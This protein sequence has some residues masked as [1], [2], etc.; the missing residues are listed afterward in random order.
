MTRMEPNYAQRVAKAQQ[1]MKE[2]QIDYAII[3]VGTD[4]F[5]MTGYEKRPS[6]RLT[7]LVV[8]K[9]KDSF[10][11]TSFFEAARLTQVKTFYSI[12]TWK[13]TEDPMNLLRKVI[14]PS[15]RT[16]IA[17]DERGWAIFLLRMQKA[18]PRAEWTSANTV[19]GPLRMIKDEYEIERLREGGRR[20]DRL[21]EQILQL[22]FS[23]KTERQLGEEI[24]ELAKEMKMNP[25]RPAGIASGPNGMS[26]HHN[27]SDRVIRAGDGVWME[28]GCGGNVNGYV[29]DKTRSVQVNPAT[30]RFK[31]IYRIVEAAHQAAFR[32]VRPS[33]T[34]ESVDAVARKVISDAGFGEYFTHRLGHG[35]GLD[36]HEEPYMVE[37]NTLQLKEGMVFSDEPGIYLPNEFGIRI[38]DIITVTKSGAERFFHSTHELQTVA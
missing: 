26:P 25:A 29:I 18:L 24:F 4:M 33:V 28:I 7:C 12:L 22:K 35:L 1:L 17:V 9:T 8:S 2:Q 16:R 36:T 30:D 27:S 32:Y 37:G 21:Y 11:I 10:M 6:E 31:Q 23:G 13:E 20:A 5:Y 38:E 15:E 3:G 14:D 34:C 19:I